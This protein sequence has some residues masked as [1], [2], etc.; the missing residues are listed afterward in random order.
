M[1]N[2]LNMKEAKTVVR[3]TFKEEGFYMEGLGC[4]TAE[5]SLSEAAAEGC[6]LTGNGKAIVVAV[7][8]GLLAD[9][10]V[11]AGSDDGG[12]LTFC[13][14][15][16]DGDKLLKDWLSAGAPKVWKQ[17]RRRLSR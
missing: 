14:W 5:I 4:D 15:R 9:Y 3:I 8:E 2:L 11:P 16:L 17:K 7:R 1:F 12:F 10:L 6:G 13:R